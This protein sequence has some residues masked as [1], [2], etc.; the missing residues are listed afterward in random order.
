MDPHLF[1]QNISTVPTLKMTLISPNKEKK[2]GTEESKKKERRDTFP[3]KRTLPFA[4]LSFQIFVYP[5]RDAA[6]AAIPPPQTAPK[7]VIV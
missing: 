3:R 4:T 5:I 2:M 1:P 6:A 7:P